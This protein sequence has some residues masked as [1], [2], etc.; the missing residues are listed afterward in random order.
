MGKGKK[1]KKRTSNQKTTPKSTNTQT[2]V[3]KESNKD[4]SRGVQK[5]S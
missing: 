2:K 3:V 4:P 1:K 5:P